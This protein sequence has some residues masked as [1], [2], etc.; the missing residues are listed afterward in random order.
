MKIVM[1]TKIGKIFC[2]IEQNYFRQFGAREKLGEKY[3][4]CDVTG[5]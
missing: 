1:S 2:P 4:F 5:S 3:K